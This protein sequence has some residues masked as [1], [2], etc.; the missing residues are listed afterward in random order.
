MDSQDRRDNASP[1]LARP[2]RC[3]HVRSTQKHRDQCLRRLEM[4]SP[5]TPQ[6]VLSSLRDLAYQITKGNLAADRPFLTEIAL[7]VEAEFWI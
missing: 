4:A 2:R 5:H 3:L 7:Q 1:F 6:G